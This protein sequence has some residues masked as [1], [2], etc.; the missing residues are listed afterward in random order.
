[1][2]QPLYQAVLMTMTP[3]AT[4]SVGRQWRRSLVW[5]LGL[6]LALAPALTLALAPALALFR[7]S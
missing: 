1:M 3:A 7:L 5:A 6:T 4:H 2:S